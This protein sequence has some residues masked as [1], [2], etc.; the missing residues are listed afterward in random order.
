MLASHGAG[1]SVL[2]VAHSTTKSMSLLAGQTTQIV[3]DCPNRMKSSFAKWAASGSGVY[4]I[5][6]GRAKIPNSY[7]EE[8]WR[9]AEDP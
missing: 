1:A 6:I 4:L 9:D 7:L 3:A 5:G 8:L 2:K